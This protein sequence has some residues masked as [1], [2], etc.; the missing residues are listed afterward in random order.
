[1]KVDAAP[2]FQTN[3]EAILFLERNSAGDYSIVAWA[4]GTF[5]IA[6]TAEG[7]TVTQDSTFHSVLDPVTRRFRQEG[8][9][10]M[11]IG[12]FKQQVTRALSHAGTGVAR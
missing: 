2:V 7:E 12:L 8:I 6:A 9:A 1:M 5:R 10:N 4:R 3:E 11:P